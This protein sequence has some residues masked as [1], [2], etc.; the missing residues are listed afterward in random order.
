MSESRQPQYGDRIVVTGNANFGPDH[1]ANRLRGKLGQVA[2]V[3]GDICS[4]E[5][6]DNLG[7]VPLF[8]HE[9]KVIESKE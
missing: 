5:L 9:F 4:I 8:N 6:D 3:F 7:R 2:A 1:S